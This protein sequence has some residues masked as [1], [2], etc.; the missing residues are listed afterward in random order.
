MS[1]NEPTRD[2]LIQLL[3]DLADG[4]LTLQRHARL[5][6]LLRGSR[7]SRDYYARFMA[8]HVELLVKQQE[9][10]H[11]AEHSALPAPQTPPQTIRNPHSAFHIYRPFTIAA[12][13][14][15]VAVGIL[16][17][18]FWPGP[19]GLPVVKQSP[20]A[21][22]ASLTDAKWS[23]ASSQAGD[24][25][26]AGQQLLL[27]SGS[28][29]ITFNDHA[30]VILQG[31]AEF[32]VVDATACR[33]ATGRLTAHVPDLAK[34]FKVH[35]PDGTVTD[36]GTDF[37][38]YVGSETGG[39]RLEEVGEE[40]QQPGSGQQADGKQSPITEV[41]VFKGQVDVSRS[42]VGSGK[43]EVIAQNPTSDL[44]PPTSTI[45]SAGQAV[46]ISEKKVEPLPAADPF[47][48]ALDKL[49]GKPRKV[50]LSD[51]FETYELGQQVQA[52]GPWVVKSGTRKGQG[53][54]VI[55]PVERIAQSNA[56]GFAPL[57]PPPSLVGRRV[58]YLGASAPNPPDTFP[59]LAREIDGR[60]LAQ[61]CQVL[62]E[63]DVFLHGVGFQ[64]SLALA[65]EIG[66][67][68]GIEL[69]RGIDAAKH[70]ADAAKQ[71]VDA[72]KTVDVAGFNW[73]RLRVLLDVAN[74][75]PRDV[76]VDRSHWRGPDGWVR[77]LSFQPPLPKLD[78]STPPRYVIFGYPVVSP[79][80]PAGTLWIDNVRIE[81]IS[82]K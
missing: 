19:S 24:T 47:K 4:A 26:N 57:A 23:G 50:L 21:K 76:R 32:V 65:T 48:F 31:P 77:D 69:W 2:E 33:L 30:R 46:T 42:D 55:D 40:E 60:L 1:S 62:L 73:Y 11:L 38:V 6:E 71:S 27:Q 52:I 53:V 22:I 8:I 37:G 80:T 68:E 43:S 25:L 44:R 7:E 67:T 51:D 29:E 13:V 70:G 61:N 12:L 81:V 35:T 39:D 9:M 14:A 74:G 66:H 54:S 18:A 15:F 20:A 56:E 34:G 41:H 64:H 58:A 45:L 17:Y 78:W 49:Q 36:L 72:T 63:F 16:A 75:V 10:F 5:I 3:S 79:S 28:A 82:E 59:L